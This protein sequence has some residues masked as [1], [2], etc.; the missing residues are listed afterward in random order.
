MTHF[1]KLL[2]VALIAALIGGSVGD[3]GNAQSQPAAAET[4]AQTNPM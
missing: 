1:G 4:V 2:P 3:F